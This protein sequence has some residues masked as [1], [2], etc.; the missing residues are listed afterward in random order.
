M[1]TIRE[2][3]P[4][5][6]EKTAAVWLTSTVKGQPFL[7]EEHWLTVYR[8]LYHTLLPV[9]WKTLLAEVDGEIEGMLSFS[10]PG[11][12]AA[13]FVGPSCQHKGH[14]GALLT[15][16]KEL[17]GRLEVWVYIQNETAL[18]FFSR[19]GFAPLREKTETETKLK[20]VLMVWPSCPN[21]L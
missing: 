2:Y 6:L 8:R 4:T 5:D 14:A 7:S 10:A 17:Y 11:E 21:T 9:E 13:L 18:H 1:T 20:K 19:S 3:R 15:A 16:A 12:I